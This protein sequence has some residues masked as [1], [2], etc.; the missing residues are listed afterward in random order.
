MGMKICVLSINSLLIN[1]E[2]IWESEIED[3][4]EKCHTGHMFVNLNDQEKAD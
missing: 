3:R 1:K 4:K 2:N